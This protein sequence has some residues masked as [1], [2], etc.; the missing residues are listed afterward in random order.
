VEV[1]NRFDLLSLPMTLKKKYQNLIQ[2][3]E[4][5]SLATLPKR[6][7]NSKMMIL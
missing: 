7:Q 2:A 1:K 3:N 6:K 4:A 5:A